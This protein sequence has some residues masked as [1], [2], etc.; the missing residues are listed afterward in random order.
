MLA[1]DADRD[2]AA[3]ALREH[4]VRGRIGLDSLSARTD[5]VLAARSRRDLRIALDG[6]PA[7]P[8]LLQ[9]GR[10]VAA[11]AARGL[12]LAALTAAHILFTLILLFVLALVLVV[13]GASAA[14]LLG[15]LVLWLVPTFLLSR[16]WRRGLRGVRHHP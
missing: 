11:A 10:T 12:A 3:E 14:E 4:Y 13:H 6:L 5:L 16:L 9:H 7:A 8:Y 2:Q 1:S 15:V